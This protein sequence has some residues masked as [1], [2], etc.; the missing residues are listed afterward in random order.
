MIV[1]DDD[2]F[3][4]DMTKKIRQD[5]HSLYRIDW[6]TG[7]SQIVCHLFLFAFFSFLFL[8]ISC[9]S[10]HVRTDLDLR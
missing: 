5:K 7:I 3:M 8:F 4:K 10:N 1:V 2:F 6:Y 9:S